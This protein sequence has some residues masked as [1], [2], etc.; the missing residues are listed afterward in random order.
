[1]NSVLAVPPANTV[2]Q[3]LTYA[4]A[5]ITWDSSTFVSKSLLPENDSCGPH[6]LDLWQIDGGGAEI[7]LDATIFTTN[8][9]AELTQLEV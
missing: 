2:L 8:A 5:G 7:Y 3:F 4:A 9:P 1:M 6:T